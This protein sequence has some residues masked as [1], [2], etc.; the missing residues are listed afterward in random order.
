MSVFDQPAKFTN[1][2]PGDR[3]FFQPN[4]SKL[5]W[6]PDE[7][8]YITDDSAIPVLV[9]GAKIDSMKVLYDV[10]LPNHEGGFYTVYPLCN[11]DSLFIAARPEV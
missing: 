2:M 3:A 8:R 5:E 1:F 7:G 6:L 4:L 11:V 10:A 9:V